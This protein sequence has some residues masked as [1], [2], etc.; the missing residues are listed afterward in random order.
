VCPPREEG[1]EKRDKRERRREQVEGEGI[2][3]EGAV[4]QK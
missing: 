2:R 1:E 4:V 3:M